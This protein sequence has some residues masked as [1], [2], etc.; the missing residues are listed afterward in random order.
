MGVGGRFLGVL[1][2]SGDHFIIFGRF[3]ARG[4]FL[5]AAFALF[6]DAILIFL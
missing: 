4:F 3:L 1:T 5:A 2:T 6:F